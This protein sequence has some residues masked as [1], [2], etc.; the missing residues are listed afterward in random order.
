MM[1]CQRRRRLL[2]CSLMWKLMILMTLMTTI[3]QSSMACSLRFTA[4]AFRSSSFP[5]SLSSRSFSLPITAARTRILSSSSQH[6]NR[7]TRLSL[8]ST[9]TP[10]ADASTDTIIKSDDTTASSNK[11]FYPSWLSNLKFGE[12]YTIPS[13]YDLTTAAT[14][15]SSPP[16]MS[17]IRVSSTPD[18]FVIRNFVSQEKCQLLIET[19]SNRLKVAGTR[20]SET[21]SVR[22][23]SYLTWINEQDEDTEAGN[24][25]RQIAKEM[26][27]LSQHLVIDERLLYNN[28]DA[29]NF[30]QVEDL[31]IV[32]YQPCGSYDFHHDGYGRFRT[33][34]TYLNGV[35]GTYFPYAR[36]V[37]SSDDGDLQRTVDQMKDISNCCIPGRD[38]LLVVGKEGI[39][40]YCDTNDIRAINNDIDNINNHVVSIEPGDAVV[41]SSYHFDYNTNGS[42]NGGDPQLQHDQDHQHDDNDFRQ[43][44]L[45]SLHGSLQVPQIKYI[46]TNWFRSPT[47]LGPFGYMYVEQLH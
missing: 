18:I 21:N 5:S 6:Q 44:D 3:M 45:R 2:S 23:H 12:T 19:T 9:A 34:L 15:S 38:G 33:V 41:F 24:I 36:N 30:V 20:K 22:K 10:N 43:R 39:D 28:P 29:I 37:V 4:T 42:S 16:M 35:G 25:E 11:Y 27:Q 47:L 46:A 31:Q 17:I 13:Y 40:A 8:S 1:H 7:Q 26:K 32:K 14:T